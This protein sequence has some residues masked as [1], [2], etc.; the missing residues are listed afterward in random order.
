[1]AQSFGMDPKDPITPS[2]SAG[3]SLADGT[4][5]PSPPAGRAPV[6]P[7]LV[8]LERVRNRV[9][10]LAH[11]P[12]LTEN[13]ARHQMWETFKAMEAEARSAT[14]RRL[15]DGMPGLQIA[16][17][18][19]RCRDT[20]ISAIVALG[21][22][23]TGQPVGTGSGFCI[24]AVGG[25]GR[26]ALAP[27][28]DLDLLFLSQGDPDP[29]VERMIQIVLYTLWDLDITVGHAS[30]SLDQCVALAQADMTVR[31][32][33]LDA[34]FLCGDE[35]LFN[36]MRE[37]YWDA[38]APTTADFVEAKLAE[39]YRR[40]DRSDNAQYRVEPNV[41]DGK[42]GLRDLHT[43]TWIAK[44]VFRF[45]RAGDLVDAGVLTP[46]EFQAYSRCLAFLWNV[47]C[48]L[49][50]LKG[51]PE[52]RLGFEVQPDLAARLRYENRAGLRAVEAF[53]KDYF[54]VT[55]EVGSLTA[56]VLS[57]LAIRDPSIRRPWFDDGDA[58]AL[59]GWPDFIVESGHVTHRE[60]GLFEREP[61]TMVTIFEAADQ[62]RV[63]V[64]PDALRR[65]SGQLQQIDRPMR[66]DP[67]ANISFLRILTQSSNPEL[68]LRR[69][70]EAGVLGVFI[71]DFG[72][73][74]AMMQ[75]NMYH[76][77]TVDEHILRTVGQ[78]HGILNGALRHEFPL[79]HRVG[80]RVQSRT[81]LYVAMLFHDI[82]K[83]RQE[84]HSIAGERVAREVCPRLGLRP[85]ETETV[86][87]LVRHH[88]LMSET[89]LRRDIF[90]PKTLQDFLGVVLTRERLRLLFT[91]T[92]A[93][94]RGVGP[95]T[96]N[97]WKAQLLEQL[98]V[99]AELA[100]GGGESGY[101]RGQRVAGVK[102]RLL[103]DLAGQGAHGARMISTLDGPAMVDRFEP[104]YWLSFPRSAYVR[105]ARLM[106]VAQHRRD[107]NRPFLLVDVVPA[108]TGMP[109]APSS[110]P[111]PEGRGA[112]AVT[113]VTADRTGLFAA[114]LAAVAATGAYLAGAQ[115][116]TAANGIALDVFELQD[117]DG[118]AFADPE[119]LQRLRR[120]VLDVLEG[121]A[122]PDTLVQAPRMDSREQA[123]SI[124]PQV[125]IDRDA[126]DTATVVEVEHRHRPD[127]NYRIAAALRDLKLSISSA[128]C[129]NYG[130]L[131]VE[132]YY[133]KD[134]GG[135]KITHE[136]VLERIETHLRIILADAEASATGNGGLT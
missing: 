96:W 127:L 70:N 4:F 6:Q 101:G 43:L 84:D 108:E 26:G 31:T 37:R 128:H 40:H 103:T 66:E 24:A 113:V 39:R 105:H 11:D 78:L 34:R 20:M 35:H 119:R 83:G 111:G 45:E 120:R 99:E 3:P 124:T 13:Q 104:R 91:L 54:L 117:A 74:V 46:P 116:F 50:I 38:V 86:V 61:V 25:Y 123:F 10:E 33:L 79:V 47:R 115:A 64:H 98:F 81:L 67:D 36:E 77:Y 112:T 87:W 63:P 76:H 15:D 21:A 18:M 72:R 14:A 1:M 49:H 12:D 16:R 132:V 125:F 85:V 80:Q 118:T 7:Y 134:Q 60:P 135:L 92:V 71:P 59:S 69:M 88:L 110:D 22:I 106:A 89:A 27:Y 75:F 52:E 29:W 19:A 8:D 56:V 68:A 129:T 65:I 90:D 44:Y 122:D 126:S 23:R 109:V 17:A 5:E 102:A 58:R 133:V 62:A 107:R 53:M 55:R 130:A 73:I 57:A 100:L 30:R 51:R 136:S 97:S 121:R 95:N 48:N 32:N 42:G 28:S 93:D 82:A 2:D 41:K 131:G 94:I 9:L 114:L